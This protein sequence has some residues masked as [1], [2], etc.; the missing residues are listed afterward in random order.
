MKL[1]LANFFID[2]EILNRN[3]Q[4]KIALGY[5]NYFN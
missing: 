4:N 3:T 1:L 5:I 2:I